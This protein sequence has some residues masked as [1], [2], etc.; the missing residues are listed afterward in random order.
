MLTNL[1]CYSTEISLNILFMT[2]FYYHHFNI[3]F[4]FYKL[5]GLFIYFYINMF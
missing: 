4:F 2:L 3:Y 5:I 1:K